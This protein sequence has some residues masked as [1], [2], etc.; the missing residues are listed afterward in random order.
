MVGMANWLQWLSAFVK[1]FIFLSVITLVMALILCP[2]FLV[3]LY[4]H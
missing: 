4:N 1:H 3:S 2:P